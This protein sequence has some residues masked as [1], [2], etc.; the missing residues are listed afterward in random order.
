MFRLADRRS[1]AVVSK[2]RVQ[3]DADQETVAEFA[4][5]VLM[6]LYGLADRSG[7]AWEYI[8]RYSSDPLTAI[9]HAL[10]AVERV[11]GM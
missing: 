8:G 7:N 10:A 4:A 9:T 11:L 5:A 3:R 1:F 2:S 6:A